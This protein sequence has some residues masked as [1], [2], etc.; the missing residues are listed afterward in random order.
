M[1]RNNQ[2]DATLWQNLLFHISQVCSQVW[3]GT[4]KRVP[5]QTW[6]RPVATFV[7]KPEAAN[8]IKAPDDERYAAPNMLSTQWTVE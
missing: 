6:L 1:I 2:Q 4:Q 5:T 8:T 3:V 7:C